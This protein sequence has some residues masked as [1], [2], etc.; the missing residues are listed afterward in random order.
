MAGGTEID[1]PASTEP[2]PFHA[3]SSDVVLVGLQATSQGLS[4]AEARRRHAVYGP[5]VL[6]RGKPDGPWLLLWRQLR[7]P[8]ILVLIVCGIVAILVDLHGAGLKNGIV[9][10]AVVVINSIIGFIQEF[11]AGKAIEALSQMV[12]EV[13]RLLRDGR[14]VS[15]TAAGLVPG[16]IVLLASGDRVPADLRLLEAKRLHIEEAA[17]T[18]E[19]MPAEK[20]TAPVASKTALGDRRCIAYGGTLVT[21]GTATAVVVATGAAT[22]LGRISTLLKEVPDLQ[23]PLTRALATIATYI[24]GA[25][26]CLALVMLAVGV[27]RTMAATD[28]GLGEALRETLIFAIALAV[29]AI[30]EGLPAIVTIALAIGVQRMTRRHTVIRKLPAVETLG[31]TTV[32]CSDKTGTLTRNEMTV[33]A[34]QTGEGYYRLTGVGY[35]PSGSLTSE[36]RILESAPEA[37]SELVRCAALCS[38]AVLH[39]AANHWTI[40]GDPTEGA[41]V[42]AA[43]KLGHS[44][45]SLRQA[46]PRLDVIAFESEHQFMATLHRG[47]SGSHLIIAK[48]APE[49]I[50]PRCESL[51]AASVLEAVES[52]AIQGLRVLAVAVKTT[53]MD[54]VRIDRPDI[55]SGLRFV[56]LLGMIDPPRPEAIEA[57]A[58]CHAAGIT[59]KM[60]TGDHPST[61]TAI[62]QQL[63]ILNEAGTCPGADLGE[64]TE[65]A[66]GGVVS[67]VNVFARVAPEQKLRLVRALQNQN[68]VVAVTGDGV[69]DAPALKQA[70]IGVAMGITG[71]AVSR[72][73]A[74]MVLIDDNF[75]SIAA[76]IEEG[77]RVYD[78]LIK[79]L[80]FVLPTNLGLALILL[81]AVA[82][83]PFDIGSEELL[84]ALSPVQLL[85][86]N[87]V[88][89]V[90]LALA[91][92]F[93][94]PEPDVMRRPPRRPNAPVLGR[95]VLFRT[96]MV[97]AL[98]TAAGVGMFL[99]D[100]RIELARGLTHPSA[101]AQAQTMAVTTIILFQI[102]Y[103]LNCRS[104]RDSFFALG[105]FSNPVI[106]IGIGILLTLQS[107]YVYVPFMQVVFGS[108]PLSAQDWLIATCV[109]AM[110]LPIVT[111]EKWLHRFF[112]RPN[113]AL[114]PEESHVG[115]A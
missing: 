56:G 61:A 102:F 88:A 68:E 27:S 71:T 44:V 10:L 25:I 91:L 82:F 34:L 79:S 85:W 109:G 76:A 16:D 40:S 58:Q 45:D 53:S 55:Q 73:A 62:A 7:S 96:A 101:L 57:V 29:G 110:I 20:D 81:Y 95:F 59:V 72:Q 32:I 105:V 36:G 51:N 50:A 9:I 8:L 48:G 30:P 19:S 108:A 41:L 86:I 111:I 42:V 69:N 87:L 17:L 52:L 115:R 39:Q 75:A 112:L 77:R 70:N 94:A 12:P 89:T 93:E 38:D 5:N 90:S 18:G 46:F 3:S 11:K 37:V 92:A 14:P 114:D 63:G 31:S 113:A 21:S 60:I 98:M 47:S 49:V 6:P 23:T 26:L 64:L 97:A 66:L 15:L 22:E 74:D 103:L 54:Q 4:T 84:L 104:L 99:W 2:A 43:E 33:Q 28:V 24:T 78:N 107:M 1:V 35:E 100:Y 65:E 67:R 83:F 13:V 106:F 80:A